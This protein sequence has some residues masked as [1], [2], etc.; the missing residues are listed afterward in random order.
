[1]YRADTVPL[2]AVRPTAPTMA[3]PDA[4]SNFLLLVSFVIVESR[5]MV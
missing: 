1:M 4:F 3:E 5:I 2:V